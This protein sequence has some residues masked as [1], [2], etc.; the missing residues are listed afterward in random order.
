M[1]F[2]AEVS[3]TNSSF[4]SASSVK[5]A[6]PSVAHLRR[7]QS[8]LVFAKNL[9]HRADKQTIFPTA[10][11]FLF[12]IPLFMEVAHPLSRRQIAYVTIF[13][14]LASWAAAFHLQ[15]WTQSVLYVCVSKHQ[16]GCQCLG[17]LTQGCSCVWLHMGGCLNIVKSVCTEK[18]AL[19]GKFLA[20]MESWTCI[21]STLDPLFYQMS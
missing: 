7:S 8:L 11:F 1:D 21:S 5:Y 6:R 9:Q 12:Y 2:K 17:F 14:S 20:A 18:E 4:T 16:Y 3:F 13:N 10:T 19:E 15:G